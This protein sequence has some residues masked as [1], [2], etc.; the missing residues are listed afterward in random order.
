M[1]TKKGFTLAEV[2][3]TLAVI[4]VV[5]ALTI[6]TL[7]QSSSEKQAKVSI[8]KAVSVLNQALTMSIAED[9]IDA[10]SSSINSAS[11]LSDLFANYMSTLSTDNA[12]NTFTAADGM[13]YT[14]Y[15]K[16][17]ACNTVTN[18]NG[19]AANC[20]VEIDINGN[21]GS[22]SVGN[23]NSYSDLY[24]LIV[25]NTSIIPANGDGSN[26]TFDIASDNFR[27]SNATSTNVDNVAMDALVN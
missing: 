11:D 26:G 12:N 7:I 9:G 17:G 3:V 13:I 16:T 8:K 20:L 23:V 25:Q 24:Y 5:A 21:R 18:A 22:N 15:R 19:G 10:A 2:L 6:P 4:G 14:F 27:G 1:K